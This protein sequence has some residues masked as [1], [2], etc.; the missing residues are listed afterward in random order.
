[1]SP[2]GP[3]LIL[4]LA[5]LAAA[6][7]IAPPDASAFPAANTGAIQGKV[8]FDNDASAL[9]GVTLTL[10]RISATPGTTVMNPPNS[11]TVTISPIPG[12]EPAA[13]ATTSASATPAADG[14]FEVDGL[15]VGQ[16]AICVKD[17]AARVIDPCLWTDS[18]TTV[19]V[20]AGSLTGGLI[21]RVKKA[22][23]IAVRV[24]DTAQALVQK[25]GEAYPPHVLV[26]AFDLRGGL[27]PAFE[28]QKDATGISYQLPIPVDSPVRLTVYS[29]Q[30]K[31]ATAQNASVPPQGYSTTLVQ[32]S[33]QAQTNSLTFNAVGRD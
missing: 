32:P 19:N 31:L 15:P 2:Q 18:R 26:A 6:A 10:V 8:V 23:A 28:T 29:A 11:G 3:T 13:T 25:A 22:S 4:I 33:T 5:L 7:A 21:V 9:S 12:S 1:M 14:S 16:Y 30:V 24:N 20:I 17:P 27:H